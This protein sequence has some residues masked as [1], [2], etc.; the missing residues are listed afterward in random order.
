MFLAVRELKARGKRKI[1]FFHEDTRNYYA[2]C[3]YESYRR[4][5]QAHGLVFEDGLLL[6]GEGGDF[7]AL[8]LMESVFAGGRLGFDAIICLNYLASREVAGQIIAHAG[9]DTAG[10]ILMTTVMNPNQRLPMPTLRGENLALKL[11]A[12]GTDLLVE[13]LKHPQPEN[14]HIA[15]TPTLVFHDV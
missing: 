10:R 2:Q 4:A 11:A 6:Q 15:F 8:D 13:K 14:K 7:N 1:A 12:L 3:C 5:L 9:R